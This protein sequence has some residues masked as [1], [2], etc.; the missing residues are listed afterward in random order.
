VVFL[1]SIEICLVSLFL[2]LVCAEVDQFAIYF[3]SSIPS[4]F[5]WPKS[6]S[7]D[8]AI[9]ILSIFGVIGLKQIVDAVIRGI[10]IVVIEV[11]R[12]FV[13]RQRPDN[14]MLVIASQL[15]FKG[16]GDDSVAIGIARSGFR[17]CV[18]SIE[19]PPSTFVWKMRARSFAPA[20]RTRCRIAVEAF[21]QE[22]NR[23]I[24]TGSHLRALILGFGQSRMGVAFAL[25][26]RPGA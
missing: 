7:R 9:K 19:I 8:A 17:I 20:Q 21:A 16:Q 26:A 18:S 10:S 25:P 5:M 3:N 13:L 22:G 12:P 4:V 1:L 2:G 11:F 14:M 15:A 24:V 23:D 6:R